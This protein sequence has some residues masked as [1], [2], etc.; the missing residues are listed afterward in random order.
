MIIESMLNKFVETLLYSWGGDT[1]SEAYWALNKFI[2][3]INVLKKTDIPH[4][5]ESGEDELYNLIEAIN[6]NCPVVYAKP[7]ADL[8]LILDSLNTREYINNLKTYHKDLPPIKFITEEEDAYKHPDKLVF[9][10]KEEN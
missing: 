5:H 4:L 9:F 10:V 2:D 7:K 8:I 1:P 3:Y 6:K